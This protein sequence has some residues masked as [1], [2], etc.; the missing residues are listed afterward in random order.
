EAGVV[1]VGVRPQRG[2]V[3]AH[4]DLHLRRA[5]PVV[6]VHVAPGGGRR[7]VGRFG[8]LAVV[9]EGA[10]AGQGVVPQEAAGGEGQRVVAVHRVAA[11]EAAEGLLQVVGDVGGV[12]PLVAGGAEGAAA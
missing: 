6:V 10:L 4:V 7:G 2:D 3:G 5:V 8:E 1:R 11:R 9:A 12:G